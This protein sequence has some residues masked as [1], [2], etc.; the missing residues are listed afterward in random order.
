MIELQKG[1][2]VIMSN[3]SHKPFATDSSYFIKNS[4]IS[5]IVS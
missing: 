2:E 5:N 4:K 1:V 3:T